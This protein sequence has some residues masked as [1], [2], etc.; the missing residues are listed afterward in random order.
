V[1]TSLA[2]ET[3]ASRAD[4]GRPPR[5]RRRAG[6]PGCRP[7]ARAAGP[8]REVRDAPDRGGRL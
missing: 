5:L 3:L 6:G 2:H 7:P 8:R 1:V 4:R